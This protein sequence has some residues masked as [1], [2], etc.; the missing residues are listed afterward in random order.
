MSWQIIVSITDLLKL[1]FHSSVDVTAPVKFAD[2]FMYHLVLLLLFHICFSLM[3]HRV[4]ITDL[5]HS[6][7]SLR[8][9]C[10]VLCV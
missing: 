7:L 3:I 1:N 6:V 9:G 5:M 8:A 2:L 4:S 10:V